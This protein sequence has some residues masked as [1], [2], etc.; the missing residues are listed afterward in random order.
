MA[1]IFLFLLFLR[2]GMG[3]F[4]CVGKTEKMGKSWIFTWTI[5]S[6]LW[7]WGNLCI[8]YDN[9]GKGKSV[10]RI[11]YG[12]VRCYCIRILY[13]ICNGEIV[14]GSVLGLQQCPF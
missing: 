12:N 6:N 9:S 1:V 11:F 10:C 7:F 8:A 3:V 14:W 4:L 2:V 13:R 5:S